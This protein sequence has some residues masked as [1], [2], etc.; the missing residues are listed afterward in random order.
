MAVAVVCISYSSMARQNGWPVGEILSKDASVPKIAAFITA[1]WIVGK[2]FVVYQWWSPLIIVFIGWF[3]A[4]VLT[5]VL[6]QNV[7]FVGVLGIF[8]ALAFTILYL[9]E[10]KPLGM[11]QSIVS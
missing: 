11:L 5:M 7:Q 8:P 9:S 4:F 10:S 2:S 1:L 3:V 6:R